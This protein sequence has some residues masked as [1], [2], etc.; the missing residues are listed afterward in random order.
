MPIITTD[1]LET[2]LHPELIA[3]ITR[4]D[5][6]ITQRAINTAV[7]EAKQYLTRFNLEQL[8]GTDMA[9]PAVDDEYLKSIVK[10]LACW[11]IIRLSG[12]GTDYNTRRT[13]YLDALAA[14]KNIRDEQTAPDGW[15]YK[16]EETAATT[17]EW[18]SNSRRN[19]YY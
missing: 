14:L 3:E 7:Q 12:T 17:I 2:N 9:P 6:T 8:F 13:A 10:D 16:E 15:P 5:D 11:H 4:D 19:N 18:H 1:E